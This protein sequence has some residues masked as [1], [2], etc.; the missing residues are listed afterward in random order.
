M[1][2]L[3]DLDVPAVP[4]SGT[5]ARCRCCHRPLTEDVSLGYELGPTCR[6][7]LGITSRQRVRLA[8][9]RPGGDCEGQGDLL[10]GH[11]A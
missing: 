8:R 10:E 2:S 6:K 1:D 7:R 5:V 9:V 3:L 11:D 4:G